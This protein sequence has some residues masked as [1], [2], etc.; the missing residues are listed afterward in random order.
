MHSWFLLPELD[1]LTCLLSKGLFLIFVELYLECVFFWLL[2][3]LFL[4]SGSQAGAQA[5]I[6]GPQIYSH[7][8]DGLS[9]VLPVS[10]STWM[11]WSQAFIGT[12]ISAMETILLAV[13]A[14]SHW[15]GV[16]ISCLKCVK[17][18]HGSV[19]RPAGIFF[20]PSLL[21]PPSTPLHPALPPNLILFLLLFKVLNVSF[22]A[23]FSVIS[24]LLFSS[25]ISSSFPVLLCF[26]HFLCPSSS[27]CRSLPF[28]SPCPQ[29]YS[30]SRSSLICNC[31]NVIYPLEK[32]L[33]LSLGVLW[34]AG[35]SGTAAVNI[36]LMSDTSDMGAVV[37]SRT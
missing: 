37:L 2:M 19:I 35:P 33:P 7:R 15:G 16:H 4:H 10:Q 6:P 32:D 13:E 9:L 26:F 11:W 30:F 34:A 5:L 14:Q 29:S 12:A 20:L 23:H 22:L 31:I 24:P 18:H 28:F 21:G 3:F 25:P 36:L 17:P 27:F 8:F 1:L